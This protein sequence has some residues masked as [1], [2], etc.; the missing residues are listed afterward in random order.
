MKRKTANP[1]KNLRTEQFRVELCAAMAVAIRSGGI[2]SAVMFSGG[3]DSI[4]L[5][6]QARQV[7][8][9]VAAVTVAFDRYN[10]RTV[11]EAQR[12]ARLL[13]ARHQ[14]VRVSLKEYILSAIRVEELLKGRGRDYD[15][16]LLHAALLKLPSSFN[17]FWAGMGSDQ[18]LGE[19]AMARGPST[20][21]R[22]SQA[23]E[24]VRHHGIIAADS[25]RE[26]VFPFLEKA[27]LD[28]AVRIPA[29]LKKGKRLLRSLSP[30]LSVLFPCVGKPELQVPAS[31]RALALNCCRK[32]GG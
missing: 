18:W 16:P 9:G 6:E 19:E 12:A 27:V 28:A 31:V 21:R 26:I 5:Y 8:P 32:R 14:V 23:R 24:M 22:R 13:K 4:F 20:A 7:F 15:I 1:E 10:P 11:L 30:D 2:P 29:P 3:F 17:R 25:G